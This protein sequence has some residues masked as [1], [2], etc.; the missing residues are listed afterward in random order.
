MLGLCLGLITP[1]WTGAAADEKP[2]IESIEV[3]A[4]E[5]I[6]SVKVPP[7]VRKVCLEARSRLNHGAWVPRAVERFTGQGGTA[8]FRLPKSAEMEVLRVRADAEEPLPAE[9]YAGRTQF[10]GPASTAP[11][12]LLLRADQEAGA[13]GG[14]ATDSANTRSVVESDIWNLSGDTLYFFNSYRGLQVID[15]QDPDA[16]ALRSTLSLPA[17]GE[18]LY[19]IQ[20]PDGDER[21]LL[22]A[23]DGCGWDAAG[24]SQVIVIDP[25]P[26]AESGTPAVVASAN[27]PGY[28]VESRLVGTALYVASQS[29][30]RTEIP[31]KEPGGAP[32]E[33]WEYG[34]VITSFDLADSSKPALR[35]Q[36]WFAG[37]GNTIAATDRFLFVVTVENG[38]W[39]RSKV[40]VVDIA[41]ADG[42][43][44]QRGVVRPAGRVADKFKMNLTGDV[45]TVI[46]EVSRWSEATRQVSVLETFSLSDPAAPAKLG[47]VEVG[48][49]EG[50]Y[51][52][53]FDGDRA[54][55][56]TF[57][58][59]DPLWVID[60]SDPA[61]P[62]VAGELE[63]PGWSNYIHPLGDRLVTIGIDN[64]NGWRATVALFDVADASKPA[65]LAKVP[66]GEGHSASEANYD[67]KAFTVL[68]DAGLILVPYQGWSEAGYA[69]RVQLIDLKTDTLTPRGVIEHA[70]QPRRATVHEDRILSIS[71]RELLSVKAT[72][73]DH[74]ELTANLELSWPVDR[75]VPGGDYVIEV[76]NGYTW[77]ANPTPV[78]RVVH[79]NN[80]T[81]VLGRLELP[82]AMPI[83]NVD[84]R[85]GVLYVTQGET[86][87]EPVLPEKPEGEQTAKAHVLLSTY[88]A[89]QL[90]EL[91]ALGSVN[92]EVESLGWGSDMQALWPKAGV[93]VLASRGYGY[94]WGGL[95]ID[96]AP[97]LIGGGLWWFWGGGSSGRLVAFDVSE[98]STPRLASD[99][100][101]GKEGQWWSF[102]DTFSAGDLIVQSHQASEFLEGVELPGQPRPQPYEVVK[103]DG[104]RETVTPPVGIWVTK[105]YLDVVDYSDP[106]TPTARPLVNLPGRLIAVSSDA[107][108]VY[109]LGPHWDEKWQ[110][111]GAEYLDASAYDGVAVALVNSMKMPADWPQAVT[112]SNGSVFLARRTSSTAATGVVETWKLGASGAFEKL[113]ELGIDVAAQALQV[114]GTVLAAQ[115]DREILVL[116]G[117]TPAALTVIGR[118]RSDGCIWP[119]LGTAEILEGKALWVPLGEYGVMTVPVTDR[120]S[121]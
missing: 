120:V 10:G 91:P 21:V 66:L 53:R 97:R 61:K 25:L 28:I 5:V 23:R 96:A 110:S 33:Q 30:R 7:G 50:L 71:G 51:A 20:T 119:S 3:N 17:A 107:S 67:E 116:D 1:G 34:T 56:V 102:S 26:E 85:E 76:A 109:T 95:A 52:T 31:P 105:H 45:F 35:D 72:D 117:R 65:L 55:I 44:A 59:I 60:L 115:A 42:A 113:G 90:P 18:Q 88:D 9:F 62:R 112:V 38:D 81:E 2:R 6:V 48:H 83:L 103:A 39:W 101:L 100:T 106:T 41:A 99:F 16:P 47:Q 87:W 8:V 27:V 24:E 114:T 68:P 69:A 40:Q 22:L 77:Y 78:L 82:E 74:P 111:D 92:A 104:T 46:S 98:P 70:M 75:V 86:R 93:L 63:T 121:P 14:A 4:S 12:S 37:Y 64:Q 36:F 13:A 73:R 29:Y 79:A 57:L 58:R 94:A 32:T 89:R 43:M 11:G 49:G 15:L 54:Y 19:V 108:L 84:L 118:G 80:P